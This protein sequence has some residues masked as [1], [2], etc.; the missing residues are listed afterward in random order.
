M[1]LQ[2]SLV[3]T[4]E[5]EYKNICKKTENNLKE[6]EGLTTNIYNLEGKLLLFWLK[7]KYTF[8]YSNFYQSIP[9]QF[10][11]INI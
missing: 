2:H 10:L 8:H 1:S 4:L 11:L 5:A 9:E 6:L 3:Q 7:E